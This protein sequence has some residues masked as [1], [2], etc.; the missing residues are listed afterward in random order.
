MVIRAGGTVR[1][2]DHAGLAELEVDHG[3]LVGDT[4]AVVVDEG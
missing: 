3:M 2:S 1:E 4:G